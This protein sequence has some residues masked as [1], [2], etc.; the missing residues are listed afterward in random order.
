VYFSLSKPLNAGQER[1][2]QSKALNTFDRSERRSHHGDTT[3]GGSDAVLLLEADVSHNITRGNAA[4]YAA[5]EQ[6]L[7]REIDSMFL[8][9]I[10]IM[11][12]NPNQPTSFVNKKKPKAVSR[13]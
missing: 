11:V 5:D 10:K 7:F 9:D 6:L 12:S 3:L 2:I 4:D 13:S 1:I 8:P